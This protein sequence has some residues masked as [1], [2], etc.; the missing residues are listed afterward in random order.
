MKVV[1]DI[2]EENY[3]KDN[4]IHFFGVYSVKLDEVIKNGTP[5]NEVLDKIRAEID[6]IEIDVQVDEH[7]ILIRTAEQVKQM[8]LKI[9]DKYRGES[10]CHSC[11]TEYDCYE[12]EKYEEKG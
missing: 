5:L 1:I 10:D 6:R 12:C 9:I 3:K 8:A 11:K 2:P 4:L 7:T